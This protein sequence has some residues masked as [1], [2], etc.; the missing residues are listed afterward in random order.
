MQPRRSLRAIAELTPL[1]T[2]FGAYQSYYLETYDAAPS[3]ISLVG[4]LQVACLY[5]FGPFTG[6][7][8]DV[9]GPKPVLGVG[10][11]IC[12]VSLMLLSLT[13]AV[14]QIFLC[15]G[16]LYGIGMSCGELG[17]GGVL[18]AQYADCDHAFL[19]L[20][21]IGF[22][23]CHLLQQAQGIRNRLRDVRSQ[24]RRSDLVSNEP[25]K[26]L[27]GQAASFLALSK[28][29]DH[30]Q[31]TSVSLSQANHALPPTPQGRLRLGHAHFGLRRPRYLLSRRTH[32]GTSS[33]AQS[34]PV[35]TLNFN[36]SSLRRSLDLLGAR[37]H[38]PRSPRADLS[39]SE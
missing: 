28:R 19:S 29:R 24:P 36:C 34:R 38:G 1:L 8:V 27:G 5:I 9:L 12:T 17:G 15:Q 13:S 35:S 16:V 39:P 31:L 10:T 6:R 20:L 18:A 23:S 32:F 25:L 30:S 3:T 26:T 4:G 33:E 11:L 14:W 21:H 37:L 7:A 2:A 22:Y